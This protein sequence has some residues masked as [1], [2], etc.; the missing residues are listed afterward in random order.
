[1]VLMKQGDN[2]YPGIK[3]GLEIHCQLTGLQSKLFCSCFC[4]YHGLE[5]NGNICP[6]CCGLPGTLPLLNKTA[7]ESA[8]MVSLA[9]DCKIPDNI[10]FYRKNYFYPDLPKNFQ[11]TQYNAYGI[12]S[13]GV[14]GSLKY[15][16]KTSRIRRIQLEEDPGRLVYESGGVD[17][18]SSY[19]LIDY[20][21]AGISLVEIV[22]EPDF[23][24][25]KDVRVFLN[26]ITSII[27]HLGVCNTKRQGSVRCDAN[28]SIQGGKRVEI[29][30]VGSF[31]EVEKA[32][33]YEIARQKTMSMHDIKVL[34][35][36]RDWDDARKVTKQSRAKEEEQ[37]YR[38]FP[39]P[40]IPTIL[41]GEEYVS[42]IR[43][44][45]PELPYERK[46][47]FIAKYELSDHIAQVLIDNK[48]LA[49]F[50]ESA[51]KIYSS[52][53][54]IA[55][56]IVTELLRYT[57]DDITEAKIT[58][59]SIS[60]QSSSLFAG[61]KIDPKQIAEL[62]IL[63]D[64]NTINR[65]TAKI[66]LTQIIKTG[67]MPSQVLARTDVLKIEDRII[68]S[69]AVESVF[70]AEKSAIRDAKNNPNV[71][72]FLLGKVMKLTKGRAD[73]K[74]TLNLIKTKLD[75]LD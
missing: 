12:T 18:S 66:I 32:L 19:T 10:T 41:L 34:A 23:T 48:E 63:I 59:S 64:R 15:G 57:D 8:C 21:R 69:E 33:N 54:E 71:A 5:P 39:E 2:E 56:W 43:K 73:P 22:T 6:I 38:Y 29:K 68:I 1:M 37:D 42:S 3:I 40:D 31:K 20:N 4:N 51:V 7:V 74:I 35:E 58:S 16:E 52:P 28:I 49:D 27:E 47:R 75:G 13:I 61:L 67:E 46:N 45:M 53:K 25:P 70:K 44:N 72:N 26:K 9:L 65:N 11:L 50:F 14:G 17:F 24:D 30:N 36:T 60:N 55:N 62:A